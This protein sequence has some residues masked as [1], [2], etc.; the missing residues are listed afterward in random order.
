MEST[1]NDNQTYYNL[2]RRYLLIFL[3]ASFID[4]LQGPYLY[5]LYLH[6]GYNKSDISFFYITGFASSALSG[7]FIGQL[8]DIFGRKKLCTF[9]FIS[10]ILACIATI[11][12]NSS[13]LYIGRIFSGTSSTILFSIFESWYIS[14]HLSYNFAKNQI[15]ST[16][17]DS[18]FYNG[19]LA[20]FAGFLSSI[21]ADG[22]KYGPTAPYLFSIPMS[23]LTGYLCMIFW[24]E[25]LPTKYYFGPF[26]GIS[27]ICKKNYTILIHVWLIQ[28][29]FDTSM[30]S[31]IFVW[32]SIL[33]P[34][35]PSNGLIFGA[36]MLCIALGSACH[37]F[38][39]NYCRITHVILLC[40]SIIIALVSTIASTIGIH[41]Q[42][43]KN[44]ESIGTYI[45]LI[46]FLFYEL[47]VGLY[48]PTISYVRGIIIPEFNRANISNWFRLPS[49][50]LICIILYFIRID[51]PD[52]RSIFILNVICLS[53]AFI[54][55]IKFMTAYSDRFNEKNETKLSIKSSLIV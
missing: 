18:T 37:N 3:L 8:A 14:H 51:V 1:N 33:D 9:Y 19:L 40:L 30:Y 42:M 31:F 47:S 11:S 54:Y 7:I 6:H 43:Q 28:T 26:K 34:I 29:L 23:L 45:C 52:N 22:F 50:I 25:N 21:L 16:F 38:L 4:W 49:N 41:V 12:K 20:I 55:S 17:A 53:I 10:T 2:K 39:I 44:V 48:F 35:R 46:S 13:I 15:S 24:T 36:F 27:I 5:K 32:T